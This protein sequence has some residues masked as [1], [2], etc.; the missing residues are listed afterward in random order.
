M[1]SAGDKAILRTQR[2]PAEPAFERAQGADESR[3]EQRPAQVNVRKAR[4]A[5]RLRGLA[6][7]SVLLFHWNGTCHVLGSQLKDVT[8][9]GT[10]WDLFLF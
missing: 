7:L 9:L 4:R 5:D 1:V 3:E 8:F 6:A 2:Q 10:Q